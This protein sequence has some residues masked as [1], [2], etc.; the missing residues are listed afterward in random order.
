MFARKAYKALEQW[1]SVS[2]NKTAALIEGARRI[3][4][5][6]VAQAFAEAEYD[7]YLLID[8]S[9]E[10]E[11]I[12]RIFKENIGDLD[13]FFR[14]LFLLKGKSLP[15]G[16]S[17][18][19]FDEVQLFP[20]ARQAIKALVKDARYSYIE[21]GSLI[22][23]RKNTRDILIPSEEHRI[24]MYPMDFEEFL[25]ACDDTVTA[26]SIFAAFKKREPLSEEAHRAIMRRF[27]E[28]I[29]VGGM[30]QAVEAF[31]SG[32]TY[33][34]VD[35]I[36]RTILSLYEEDLHKHDENDG[37]LAAAIFKSVPEQLSHHN[38]HFKFAAID[39]NARYHTMMDSLDFL[40]ESMM[41]NMCYD[42]TTPDIML[43]LHTEK[44]NFKMFMGD[45]GLLV[46]QAS[47]SE[48]DDPNALYKALVLGKA[49]SNLGMV[50]EN[51]IAQMLSCNGHALRFH[52]FK[53]KPED[54]NRERTYEI[55]FLL[56][57]GKRLCPVEVKSSGYRTHKS[58]DCF[59]E[60]YNV[61]MNEQFILYTKNLKTEGSIIY[62]PLYMAMCL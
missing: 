20:L 6:T 58:L 36:K 60:K 38:S 9:L 10:D 62:L 24:K 39:Q 42:V 16:R 23:I 31:V 44:S 32:G 53:Y 48:S 59:K 57:R 25:M 35:F 46:T 17:V 50:M 7:D 29:A 26:P 14:N 49:N 52:E 5:S 19:I 18:I 33:E 40:D 2:G 54:A 30:P 47:L 45:T 55:D 34:Q 11:S 56:V 43:D 4:K 8:F 3:G 21:T 12:K 13:A 1:K 61:K 28:Y 37:G 22:S 51:A 27:R 41:V 15:E